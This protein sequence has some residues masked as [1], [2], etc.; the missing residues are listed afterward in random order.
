MAAAVG[1]AGGRTIGAASAAALR[2]AG[3][4]DDECGEGGGAGFDG[5]TGGGDAAGAGPG[6]AKREWYPL[7]TFQVW[8]CMSGTRSVSRTRMVVPGEE[9]YACLGR[10]VYLLWDAHHRR[11]PESVNAFRDAGPACVRL[12][13]GVGVLRAASTEE[14]TA[15][16]VPHTDRL[17]FL[18][19]AELSSADGSDLLD[20][21]LLLQAP[22]VEGCKEWAAAGSSLATPWKELIASRLGAEG[23]AARVRELLRSVLLPLPE[24]PDTQPGRV[25][26]MLHCRGRR[27]ILNAH[28]TQQP[29]ALGTAAVDSVSGKG[30][31]V[32]DEATGVPVAGLVLRFGLLGVQ[33]GALAVLAEGHDTQRRDAVE[34][35][36]DVAFDVLSRIAKEMQDP[37]DIGD[38][39]VKLLCSHM[40]PIE[41][42]LEA[43]ERTFFMA[44]VKAALTDGIVRGWEQQLQAIKKQIEWR[45]HGP[46]GHR[47]NQL[48][49]K[50]SKLRRDLAWSATEEPDLTQLKAP[51]RPPDLP[52]DYVAGINTD[53]HAEHAITSTLEQYAIQRGGGRDADAPR[54]GI[55]AI[56]GSGKST[57]CAGVARS[58]RVR[59]L[60]KKGTAW[61]QL[62]ASS[63]MQTVVD[64]TVALVFRFCGEAV[65]MDLLSL[66]ESENFVPVAAGYVQDTDPADAAKWL[67]VIDDVLDSKMDLLLQLLRVIPRATPVLFTTRSQAVVAMVPGAKLVTIASV[68]EANARVLIA[69]AVG[70]RSASDQPIFSENEEAALVRPVLQQTKC[71]SLSLSIVAALIAN[72][73]GAW[74]PVVEALKR[75]PT[76]VWATLSTSL[77]LLPDDTYRAAFAAVGI[78]PANEL[79]GVHVLQRLWRS[80][81]TGGGLVGVA[82]SSPRK[83]LG[84]GDGSMHPDVERVVDALARAGLIYQKVAKGDLMGVVLHPVICDYARSL[85][86]DD[87]RAVHQWLLDDYAGGSS[88]DSV[89]EHGWRGYEFWTIPDDGYWSNNVVRHAAAARNICALVS[90]TRRQWCHARV[91]TGSPLAYRAD[92]KLVRVALRA[93]ERNAGYE[94]RATPVLLGM[95]YRGLAETYSGRSVC[96][97][98][99]D[100][101]DA[102]TLLQRGLELVRRFKAPQHWARLQADLGVVYADLLGGDRRANVEAAVACYRAALEVFTRE[103]TPLQWATTQN[104]LGNAYKHRVSG[105]RGANVEA[106]VACYR[107]ALEVFTREAVPLQW[108]VT[109][110][111]L[112]IAYLT[113]AGGDRG[114]NVEAAVACLHA[115]LEVHTRETAPLDWAMVQHNL[116]NTYENRVGRDR[117]AN[118]EAAVA[119]Y[120]AALEVYT[121]EAAPQDWA[122]TTWNVLKALQDGDRQAEALASARALLSFGS[123]WERWDMKRTSLATRIGFLE[124]QVA[125]TG[126][127][128]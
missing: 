48:L 56:G 33:V 21:K 64:A 124:G 72:R 110:N 23:D 73:S 22:S 107:A 38:A 109:Q 97:R 59:G 28:Y 18:Q 86:G 12:E 94:L 40:E 32:I 53:G 93:M 49:T 113:L 120:R 42:V 17:L 74:R 9:V 99:K 51:W 75:Q 10:N 65:A 121:R 101:E 58:Q 80:L 92:L 8:P 43:V 16:G 82:G 70:K 57:A 108:A 112:G 96:N 47:I 7:M 91:R 76:G 81:G 105:E 62:T 106:A 24:A 54:V 63:S 117:G 20:V 83:T 84:A 61:V 116:G 27:W 15:A 122:D 29:P 78:L 90:L 69:R 126:S 50:M 52:G 125:A 85:L 87:C 34:R 67:V 68:P 104:N 6:D 2:L 71:H 123:E 14:A 118:V 88:N 119:C 89:D 30:V 26:R 128:E 114:A 11:A 77:Q 60:F 98:A 79:I 55:R 41:G 45:Y 19:G 44:P 25:S 95:L 37:N 4:S 100:L 1:G 66:I 115:A 103:A 35:C 36:E 127:Y 13:Y 39:Y 5:K 31:D 111:N 102:V 46:S 3:G